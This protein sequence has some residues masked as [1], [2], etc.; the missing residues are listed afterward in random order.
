MG[1][2]EYPECINRGGRKIKAPFLAGKGVR[3]LQLNSSHYLLAA[4]V[5]SL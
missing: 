4:R 3:T 1:R 2:N 5:I